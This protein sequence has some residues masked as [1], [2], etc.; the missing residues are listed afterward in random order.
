MV[1]GTHAIPTL[2]PFVIVYYLLSI[3]TYGLSMSAGLFIPCLLVGAAWGRMIG[4]ALETYLP[5][6]VSAKL[7]K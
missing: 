2:T 6:A 1:A 7:I 5:A 4:I 3:W